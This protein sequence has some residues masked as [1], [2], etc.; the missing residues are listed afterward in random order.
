M[1]KSRKFAAL[2][3]AAIILICFDHK[4]Y[5]QDESG[6]ANYYEEVPRVFYG[7]LT[8]G[9]N[10]A[11]VDGDRF[12]GYHKIGGNVGGIIYAQLA[13]HTAL[14]MEILYSQKGSKSNIVLNTGYSNGL[15]VNYII[16]N[17]S[18]NTNYAEV[19]VMINYFDKRKSHF[20]VGVAY[21]R[22]VS[23]TENIQ[24]NLG[25]VPVD[26]AKFQFRKDNADIIAGAQLH[27]VKGLFLN[28]RFQY[29]LFPIRTEVPLKP[30]FSRASQ[31]N[32]M[33]VIRLMYLFI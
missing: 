25:G 3:M 27:L 28:V 30:Y 7:G 16:T 5:A 21:S 20:G 9:M 11:Q 12:A 4:A 6:E 2:I 19:P 23:Y 32:N 33:W 29:S 14:S 24:T 15:G 22:L 1:A 17:Y 8:G 31:Y 13:K 10:L 26:P 18:I